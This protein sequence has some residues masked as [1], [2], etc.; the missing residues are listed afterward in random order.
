[1][2]RFVAGV[3]VGLVLGF[4]LA[5]LDTAPPPAA[6]T[7]HARVTPS[8]GKPPVSP[9]AG[10][11]DPLAALQAENAMLRALNDGLEVEAHGVA[12]TWPADTPPDY[13]EA[14][15]ANL[16]HAL[17]A[18]DMDADLVMTDCQ[19]PPCEAWFRNASEDFWGDLINAC[20]AWMDHYGS[21]G[22]FWSLWLDCGDGRHERVIA[23]APGGWSAPQ[24]ADAP[25]D[26]AFLRS[27]FRRKANSESWR[28]A[29]P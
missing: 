9:D 2:K 14:F 4:L 3:G 23:I 16:R 26:N 17:A 20:P 11:A 25:E 21:S 27:E 12:P 29:A 8:V 19:E 28:C 5:R 6:P 7:V 13:R 24:P 1:M 22:Y 18:C 15:E 10:S